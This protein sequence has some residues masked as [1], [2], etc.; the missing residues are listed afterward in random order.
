MAQQPRQ[1]Q[2]WR[3]RSRSSSR[4]SSGRG[5]SSDG[6][7][8]AQQRR[9]SRSRSSTYSAVRPSSSCSLTSLWC[10]TRSVRTPLASRARVAVMRGIG[11]MGRCMEL[12]DRVSGGVSGRGGG[13]LRND[14]GRPGHDVGAAGQPVVARSW[15]APLESAGGGRIDGPGGMRD[16][17]RGREAQQRTGK[18]KALWA[19][20]WRA[21]LARALLL[22]S[23]MTDAS[24]R[25]SFSLAS[26]LASSSYLGAE[27]LVGE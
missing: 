2:R 13:S 26:P 3:S 7:A 15:S 18:S 21:E 27:E 23:G 25:W 14:D 6:L 20:P 16:A 19:V 10:W 4:G 11:G 24:R 12:R 8:A 9:R 17:R 1:Q 22:L 5:S